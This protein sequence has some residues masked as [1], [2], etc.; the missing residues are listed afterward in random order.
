M[1]RTAFADTLAAY[2]RLLHGEQWQR[3]IG[4]DLNVS[5]RT[6]RHWVMGDR[7]PRDPD[8]VLADLQR[9][10]SGR[11]AAIILAMVPPSPDAD[12]QEAISP[13]VMQIA[14]AAHARGWHPADAA[15]AILLPTLDMI[16]AG[17]GPDGIRAAVDEYLSS[18]E[19]V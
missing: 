19:N 7:S 18:R 4:R 15:M 17:A 10:L 1:A 12:I 9:L 16:R 2:G 3:G 8:Q 13:V 6:I 5:E 11:L 14:E